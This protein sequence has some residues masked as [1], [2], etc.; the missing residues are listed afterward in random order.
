LLADPELRRAM[1]LAAGRFV[2][3]ERSLRQAAATV[4]AAL[5]DAQEIRAARR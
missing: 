5:A 1:G 3:E 2:A 4:A